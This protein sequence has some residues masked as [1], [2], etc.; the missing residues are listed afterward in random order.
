[1]N[2]LD[3]LHDIYTMLERGT[4][5]R[6]NI[7]VS[8]WADRYRQVT[9]EQSSVPGQWVTNRNPMLREIMDCMSKNS[10]V[11]EIVIKKSSQGGM[12][13]AMINAIGY[14]VDRNPGP[15]M[16]LLPTEQKR[17]DWK[18]QKLNP[19]LSATD[20]VSDI[21][22]ELKSRDAAQRK[23]RVDFPGG[24][25][26]LAGGNSPTSYDQTS[27]RDM[28]LDDL[29]RFPEVIGK[30]HD[31]VSRARG[32]TKAF[33]H[34][35]RLMLAST[36]TVQGASLIDR[37]W[38]NSDQRRYHVR[39]PH[40]GELQ[41][42]QWQYIQYDKFNTV[43]ASAWYVCAANGC[44]ILEHHKQAMLE[45]GIWI[46]TNPDNKRRGYHFSAL[47]IP[48]G[49]GPSWLE[50]A[51]KWNEIHHDPI[52]G[53]RRAPDQAQLMAFIN[54]EL[55]EVWEDQS[56][57]VKTNDLER[58]RDDIPN[59]EI[60]P[61]VLDLT[62]AVDT[63][64]AWLDVEL[65]GWRE[66]HDGRPAWRVIDWFQIHGDTSRPDPWNELEIYVNQEWTNAYGRKMR[67]KA[68]A[69]DNRGHRSEHVRAFVARDTLRIPVYRVQG[70][71]R[72]MDNYI[73]QTARDPQKSQ[74]GKTLLNAYGIWNVGTE[75]TK[76][77]IYSS[78]LGDRESPPEERRIHFA[79]NLPTE[80]FNGLL[81]E[82]KNPKTQ[83]YE[84]KRGAEFKRNEPLDLTTYNIAI[85]HHKDVMI[86]VRRRRLAR[87]NGTAVMMIVP[88]PAYWERRRQLLEN[89]APVPKEDTKKTEE[90]SDT[91]QP[92]KKQPDGQQRK[93][94]FI[95]KR[96]GFLRR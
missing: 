65:M 83:R 45:A 67:P 42:L 29:D 81:S 96:Q 25:L 21:I 37:E 85:G 30:G 40:C 73:A 89:D 32:R 48:L 80:F 82:V 74:T 72:I 31:P 66:W 46:P 77:T 55:G 7:T 4:R 16:V 23:D 19:L 12:T 78:L 38:K 18:S 24:F 3:C 34:K 28:Y 47:Y 93:T 54:E 43:P 9:S 62:I 94:G 58:S 35:Y 39:C 71:T 15:T 56:T 11:H 33:P 14:T 53:A 13:E 36:P 5:Q 69:I 6:E 86:G 20:A 60:P 92:V 75:Y 26:L 8:E 84:Q 2:Y 70:A 27:I 95:P 64:D 52:S 79:A 63:Q 57:T 49:L 1:M 44:Q 90:K 10:G 91:L 76:D 87:S 50:L 17:D 51:R 61:G 41:V 22:G 88:N 68:V 59:G